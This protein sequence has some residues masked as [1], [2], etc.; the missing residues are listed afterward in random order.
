LSWGY[1]EVREYKIRTITEFITKS[2]FDG[3]LLDYTRYFGNQTGYSDI[4]VQEFKKKFDRDPFT[5]AFDD[6]QWLNFRANYVTQFVGDL[7]R[8]LKAVNK[9]LKVLACVAPDPNECLLSSMNNW[10]D[11]LDK[12]YIDGV[13]TMIY[14]RN[15]NN[16]LKNIAIANKA[17]ANRVPLIPMIACWGGNL[18]TPELLMEG[19][20]KCIQV[21]CSGLA[22]YRSDAIDE[23]NMW[24]TI[25]EVAALNLEK[26]RNTP[27]NYVLNAGFENNF[28]NWA[29]GSAQCVE[30]SNAKFHD[31]KKS[32]KLTLSAQPSVR[33]IIDRGFLPGYKAVHVSAW[34]DTAAA[35][36]ISQL[37]MELTVNYKNGEEDCYRVPVTIANQTGWK[38]WS[39]DIAIKGSENLN[40][41][42]AGITGKAETGELY[43][44]SINLKLANTKTD[45]NQFK[46]SQS[47]FIAKNENN[48][49]I[50]R[51]QIVQGSSFWENG[52]QYEYAVDGN[53][54]ND[55]GG[56]DASWISQRPAKDQWIK[57]Y[58]PQ[59][60]GVSKIRML[61]SSLLYCY[62][63]K[64]YKI[65]MSTNDLDYHTVATGTLPND[66]S[67]WTE[68][69][70]PPT[71]A[72]Y[73]KFT[74]LNGYHPDYAVGLK[75]IEVY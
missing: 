10:K 56:K 68:I 40:F 13:V 53:L 15:T 30:I 69:N 33:Q 62:R 38:Q 35:D 26:V 75:E 45:P 70:I 22:Y 29:T 17:I 23:L 55:N 14:E 6:Q 64:D 72:K 5:L 4:I 28:E 51:G 54:S 25:K 48:V 18:N 32:L 46:Y 58:L 65:E 31:G 66:D 37:F 27:I 49:N 61:N 20:R 3:I 67:T 16:T 42:I 74:G 59:T 63:T 19:S 50:A 21:G 12:G 43:V 39:T 7:N 57:I 36:K 34:L 9:K 60:F 52:F 71:P 73:L 24:D 2:G 11:W 47:S 41:I 8:S 1:P 44:D